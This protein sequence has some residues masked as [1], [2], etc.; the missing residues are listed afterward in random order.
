MAKTQRL[1]RWLRPANRVVITLNHLGLAVGTQHVLSVAGR[2]TGRLHNTPVS[3]LT[4]DGRRTVGTGIETDWVKNAR[5]NS[6]GLLSRGRKS[7]L[8][9]LVERPVDERTAILREFPRQIPHR[10]AFFAQIA[11]LPNDPDALAAAAPHWPVFRVDP[12]PKEESTD[13]HI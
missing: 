2:K 7:E 5:A 3:L 13:A 6:L 10:V 4:V 12:L 11:G 8:M 9:A 1:P